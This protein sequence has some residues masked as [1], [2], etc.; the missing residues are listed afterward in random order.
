MN[1]TPLISQKCHSR[2]INKIRIGGHIFPCKIDSDVYYNSSLSW[3]FLQ[4]A[5]VDAYWYSN[6]DS[7]AESV[8]QW[9]RLIPDPERWPS[10]VNGVGFREVADQVHRL[11]LKFG[12]HLHGGISAMAVVVNN[13]PILDISTVCLHIYIYIY[14][15]I[16]IRQWTYFTLQVTTLDHW[17][18]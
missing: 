12:V 15:Y 8:D 7:K 18:P 6:L 2:L 13:T 14:I 16:Y 4:I 11:G 1:F 3:L 17:A 5:I 10:S 9:G